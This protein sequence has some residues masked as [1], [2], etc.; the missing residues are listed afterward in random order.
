MQ[1]GLYL[2]RKGVITADELVAAL[3]VQT[4][5]LVR[6]GQ[7][8]LE[9]CILSARDIFNILRAQH[10]LPHEPFGEQAIRLGLLTRAELM[11]LL[12]IQ[13]DRRVPL[14]DILVRQGV[15]TQQRADDELTIYRLVQR[16][17]RHSE[18][19]SAILPTPHRR[20]GPIGTT[21]ATALSI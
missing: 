8:A 17:S 19:L 21:D 18:T 1:F 11:R 4:R 15:L 6:I 9:E 5:N 13:A 16:R 12:M 14:G 20:R 7:L 2:H 10:D 3:E